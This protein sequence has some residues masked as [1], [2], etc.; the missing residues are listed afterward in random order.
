MLGQAI[1]AIRLQDKII[2]YY[3]LYIISYHIS[4]NNSLS[5]SFTSCLYK[6]LLNRREKQVVQRE[7]EENESYS[8][9][10]SWF[11]FYSNSSIIKYEIM[12]LLSASCARI[13][14]P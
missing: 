10:R 4:Y 9:A 8:V 11:N 3:A 13:I 1:I 2:S 5:L 14:S 6:E 12:D 7:E